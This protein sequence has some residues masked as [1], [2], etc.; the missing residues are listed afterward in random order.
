ARGAVFAL[1]SP[2]DPLASAVL[3]A[4]GEL[5]TNRHVVADETRIALR[6]ADGRR[7]EGEVVPGAYRGDLVLVRVPGLSGT[8]RAGSSPSSPRAAKGATTPSPLRKLPHSRRRAGASTASRAA[9]WGAPTAAASRVST[10]PTRPTRSRSRAAPPATASFSTSPRRRWDAPE[11]WPHRRRYSREALTLD[12]NS[13]N[14]LLGLAVTLH[15][16]ERWRQEVAVL[17]NLVETLPTDFRVLRMS[18]QAAKHAGETDL[19]ER[20][21]ALIEKH[22]RDVLPEA[23]E[24]LAD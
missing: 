23:R 12:P 7:I 17:R 18:V 19:A 14:S 16:A 10:R 22:H 8:P 4:P 5:V 3:V 20:A 6:L 9:S 21:L 13:V 15:L 11:T 1:S 2:F 24:F